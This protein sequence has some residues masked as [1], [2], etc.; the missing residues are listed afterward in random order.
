MATHHDWR[1]VAIL[2]GSYR[3]SLLSALVHCV[4]EPWFRQLGRRSPT[5]HAP[6]VMA[7]NRG[8]VCSLLPALRISQRASTFGSLSSVPDAGPECSNEN[9][10]ICAG[11]KCAV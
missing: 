6:P 11:T 2:N 4:T 9:V 3:L 8:S 10:Q 7:P 5:G 1:I